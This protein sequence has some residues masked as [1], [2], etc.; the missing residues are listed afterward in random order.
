MIRRGGKEINKRMRIE[1]KEGEEK[2]D[3]KDEEQWKRKKN[4]RKEKR[5]GQGERKIP[6]MKLLY[7]ITEI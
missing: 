2:K 1:Q 5:E 4:R 6:F 7:N 3:V